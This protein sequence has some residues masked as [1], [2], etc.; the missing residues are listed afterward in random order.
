MFEPVVVLIAICGYMALLFGVALFV[1]RAAK[2][3]RHLADNR[4]VYALSL[5]VYCTAWTYYG[6]VGN[7]V[8]GGVLY[9][10]IYLGPTVGALFWTVFLRRIIRLRVHHR[11][12]SIADL[13]SLRYD[14]SQLV[15]AVV[16]LIALC[17]V[18]PYIALQLRAVSW[19]FALIA[20]GGDGGP[21][22]AVSALVA[23]MMIAFTL[24]FGIRRLDASER[25]QGLVVVVAIECVVKLFALLAAALF[26]SFVLFDGPWD[27]LPRWSREGSGSFV[28]IGEGGGA[29][30]SSWLAAM[31]L[32]AGA[33]LLLPR[34]FQ[35]AVVE[36]FRER[37]VKTASWAFPLYLLLIGVAVVPI[38]AGAL[39][40]NLPAEQADTFVLLLPLEHGAELM[41]LLVFIGGF[42]AATAMV[43]VS[44]TATSTMVSNHLVLPLCTLFPALGGLRRR[45]LWVRWV[46]AAAGIAVAWGF[47]WLVDEQVLLANLGIVAFSAV[48]QLAVPLLGGLLWMRAT[49]RGALL[50][51]VGGLGVWAYTML[52]PTL[53]AGGWL[54]F[55]LPAQG[56][57]LAPQALLGFDAIDPTMN[58][59]LWSTLVNVALFV[60]GSLTEPLSSS[61]QRIALA[62]GGGESGELLPREDE[63]A[64]RVE[65]G[66]KLERLTRVLRLYLPPVEARETL[67]ACLEELSL[68]RGTQVTMP[69]LAALSDAAERRLAG[70]IGSAAAHHAMKRH[71]ILDDEESERLA[72][73]YAE[74]LGR[75]R[76]SPAELTRRID[77][78]R[79][80]EALLEAQANEM[81]N[82]VRER[83]REIAVRRR[84]ELALRASEQKLRAVFDQTFQFAA[85]LTLDGAL[86][87][88]NQSALEI[89][90]ASADEVV[91]RPFVDTPW[92]NHD[93]EQQQRLLDALERAR[94]GEL[95]R[96]EAE[97][98]D[99]D[100]ETHRVD[101]SIKPVHDEK[102]RVFM[103]LA[104]GRDVTRRRQL[105]E[106]LR[107]AQKMQAIGTL[108]SGIAH[109]FNNLLQAISGFAQL[110]LEDMPKDA[111]VRPFLEEI[112]RLVG[113]GRDL[114]NGLLSF[115]R[116]VDAELRPVELARELERVVGVLERVL[117]RMIEIELDASS[118]T[119]PVLGDSSRL[120]Q[121]VMNLATNARDAMPDGG[122][123]S[124]SLENVVLGVEDCSTLPGLEPGPHVLFRVSDSGAG[125]DQKTLSQ[126]FE[127]FFTT[128]GFGA[129]TGLGLATTYGIVQAHRGY[130]GCYSQP[131]VGTTFS[132]YL[133]AARGGAVEVASEVDDSEIEGGNETILFVDDELA[134]RN[135]GARCLGGYGYSVR[136]AGGGEEALAIYREESTA[137]DLVVLDLGMPGMGGRRCL[138]ELRAFDPN[139]KVLVASG[140]TDRTQAQAVLQAGAAAFLGKP[141]PLSKLVR[142]VRS[143]L[144]EG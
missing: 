93:T 118:G 119:W 86:L 74:L 69:R 17:G 124:L 16:T 127:P 53:A 120:E 67:D 27:L 106:R 62:F 134:L 49:R 108:S 25:H 52:L 28:Q 114:T 32:S 136:T 96:F 29:T 42:S 88:V 109:D 77:F 18:T 23:L 123:L 111:P 44:T 24:A 82:K 141:Y 71:S 81:A 126:I 78:F 99:I 87:E 26:V 39:L 5:A 2:N 92:W 97:H 59:L 75:L 4:L 94:S 100:G 113:G 102:G 142:H 138:E 9:L 85:M 121:A 10:G 34:Q 139:V 40:L 56:G 84:A 20:R 12:T 19:T 104:E 103:L 63:S 30:L 7:V 140:Y 22:G 51:M 14:R 46:G 21:S 47:G 130:I 101:T 72:R 98:V 117:P 91:G 129:G 125:M 13:I 76:L 8:N 122:T 57:L 144:D 35:V 137:I 132:L 128:K 95:T 107:Q 83:D 60:A 135:I 33:V 68:E 116:P 66:P 45:L 73:A 143:V 70:T 112:V 61:A 54:P 6:A 3:G 50:G 133:P 41:T 38:A 65:L 64:E 15:A 105:E 79:E 89:I 80:R 90:G 1:E 36:S 11:V 48:F 110:S 31:V 55:S 37:H 115:G 58:T 43:I 131:G